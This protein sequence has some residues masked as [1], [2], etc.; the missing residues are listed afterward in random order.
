M[1]ESLQFEFD[2]LQIRHRVKDLLHL[3]KLPDLNA[4]LLFIGVQELGRW[5]STKFKKEEKQDLMH[6][7]VCTLMSKD[8]YY[9]WHGL[10]TEGWPHFE[11]V[12]VFEIK[13]VQTQ[14]QYL[15]AKAIQYFDEIQLQ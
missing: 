11:P 1:D 12:R 8:G 7:A 10:D 3:D 13:G 5:K 9:Q 14:E 4:V 6:I 2:W 15:K